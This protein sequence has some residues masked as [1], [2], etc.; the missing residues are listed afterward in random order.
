MAMKQDDLIKYGIYGFA[1][2]GAYMLAQR[3]MKGGQSMTYEQAAAEGAMA[4]I[5]MGA[6]QMNPAY[7]R[8]HYQHSGQ[9]GQQ[10]YGAVHM[11]AIHA[12][13]NHMGAIQL[14]MMH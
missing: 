13:P 2:F 3:F 10:G 9:M 6:I 14:G 12:N 11:G 5:H 4:G 7:A 8:H 1:I